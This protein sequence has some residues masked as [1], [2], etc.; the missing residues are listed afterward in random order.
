MKLKGPRGL[1][2]KSCFVQCETRYCFYY[3]DLFFGCQRLAYHRKDITMSLSDYSYFRLFIGSVVT[4][5]ATKFH[6]YHFPLLAFSLVLGEGVL[7]DYDCEVNRRGK[8]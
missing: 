2:K 1:T 8:P 3:I 5:Y 6:H 7:F 4:R